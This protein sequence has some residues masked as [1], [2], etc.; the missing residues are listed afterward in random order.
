MTEKPLTFDVKTYS[1]P[2]N[3]IEQALTLLRPVEV[4]GSLSPR[5]AELPAPLATLAGQAPTFS[6]TALRN[7]LKTKKIA[8][9]DLGGSLD[10][11]LSRANDNDPKAPL[12]KYFIIHD[13]STPNYGK[14][15]FPSN[16]NSPA[17]EFNDL[18]RWQQG[19]KSVAHVFTNRIG[20]SVTAVDFSTPW[21]STK[22]ELNTVYAARVKGLFLAV[23]NTQPRKSDLKF[24]TKNDRLAPNPGFPT[25]Q[26]DR[27]ALIYACASLRRGTWLIPSYHAALD[28]GLTDGHDDPQRF[29]LDDWC[30]AIERL[31][32][33]L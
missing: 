26:Y 20:G 10:Q 24:G 23:E 8:E 22:F 13:T 12:A 6:K 25:A 2:G 9:A 17:W 16:I 28:V 18:S 32:E 5:L 3:E 4:G 15:D 33:S 29:D 11:S 27:L 19:S 14:Q 31:L 30:A 1:F 7:Y 21:R